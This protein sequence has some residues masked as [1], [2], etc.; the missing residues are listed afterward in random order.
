MAKAKQN[1]RHQNGFGSIH[2]LG[3]KR[4][5]PYA[6]RITTGWKDGKQ[7]RKYLGYYESEA[8]ALIAL[9]EYHKTGFD[10]DMSKFTLKETF[11][12]WFKTQEKRNLSK[13]VLATHRMA[14]SRLGAL[15]NTPIKNIK[16]ATLQKWFDSVDLKPASKGKVKST[17]TMVYD[18][19]TQNDIVSKNYAKFI[20][21][22]EKV[23][24][25]GKVYTDEE[26][27]LLWEHREE[28]NAR[29]L[30]ILMYTGLR[31]GELLNI[32]RED[33]HFDEQYM[34]GGLKTEAG[35]DR[36]IPIHSKI[37]PLITKQ[38]GDNKWM[39]QARHGGQRHYNVLLN[40]NI[41]FMSKY[42]LD[43]KFHD[44]RKTAI[45]LMHTAGI[46]MET[47]KIIV[48]HAGDNVTE[49]IYLYKNPNELVKEINRIE[50]TQ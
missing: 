20:K 40:Q 19:A 35:R 28:E 37:M 48:G 6:V 7:I 9:A 45:S 10:V 34:I 32:S 25:T 16:T 49:K 13:S 2:K 29:I 44:T 14:Y 11:D 17:L 38:L 24:K 15:G 5:K 1:F 42:G 39:I 8:K 41:K 46:P 27:K 18:Y 23:E 21:M 31:V 33:I 30:L 50:I 47:V 43:H 3:G 22:D 26:I 12:E 36:I 4:R